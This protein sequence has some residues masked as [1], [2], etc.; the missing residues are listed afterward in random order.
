MWAHYA[1]Q[2]LLLLP[3]P[4]PEQPSAPDAHGLPLLLPVLEC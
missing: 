1:G 2:K 3:L 4:L